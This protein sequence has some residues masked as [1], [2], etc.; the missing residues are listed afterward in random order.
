M[1]L[2]TKTVCALSVAAAFIAAPV[3]AAIISAD[4]AAEFD[5]PDALSVTD[6]LVLES[7]GVTLGVGPELDLSDE[8][9]NPSGLVGGVTVDL[10]SSGLLTL[11]GAGG[12]FD[13]ASVMISDIT[14]VPGGEL[15]GFSFVGGTGLFDSAG[16]S[17]GPF[18]RMG[19]D[20][21]LIGV[22]TS[23]TGGDA[24]F[25][26]A[27]GGTTQIQLTFSELSTVPLPGGVL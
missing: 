13:F 17:P 23:G 25:T 26:F 5:Q 3:S 9:S 20:F 19:S 8:V 11:T 2:I 14:F 1:R 18:I 12:A 24:D 10:T 21:F 6:P 22:D 16:A 4:F 27:N 7:L 15:T